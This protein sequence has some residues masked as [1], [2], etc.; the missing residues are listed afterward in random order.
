MPHCS[1][2]L[3][4][5]LFLFIQKHQLYLNFFSCDSVLGSITLCSWQPA[6]LVFLSDRYLNTPC[7]YVV[8]SLLWSNLA[9]IL[10]FPPENSNG[11]VCSAPS[12]DHIMHIQLLSE[13]SLA[14]QL[15][16]WQLGSSYTQSSLFSPSREGHLSCHLR[17][18]QHLSL[19]PSSKVKDFS[20]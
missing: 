19:V 1:L 5:I 7:F 9:P 17:H 8:L 20:H 16:H 2:C 13:I 6:F 10:L 18:Y 3:Q 15:I 14:M 4:F 12:S 11:Q